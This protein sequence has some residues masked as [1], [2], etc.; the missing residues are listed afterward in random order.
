MSDDGSH[1]LDYI[2]GEWVEPA[3]ELDAWIEDPN[4]GEPRLRQRATDEAGVEAALAAAAA[5]YPEWS[6]TAPDARA[7]LLD[8]LADEVEPRVPA[9]AEA[10]AATSGAVVGMTMM[11]G[12]ITQGAFRL[13]A[14]MLRE[15][16]TA[17]TMDGDGGPVE[18][19]HRGRGPALLLCPWNAPAPMAAHKMASALA[20]GCP[21]IIKPPERA[22][23]G[24]AVLAEAA[25]AVGLAPGVVQIVHGGPAVAQALAGDDRIRAVSFTGGQGAG[26]LVSRHR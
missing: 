1:P 25:E 3:I 20:A 7:D 9:S 14:G 24:S 16:V 26:H 2:A 17:T 5:A 21:V 19:H 18:I 13:A 22:P 4:T 11:L 23:H 6:A 15:G 12:F 8:A 10:E